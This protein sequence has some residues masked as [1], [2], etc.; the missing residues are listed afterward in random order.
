MRRWVSLMAMRRISW[1]D[2]RIKNDASVEV[3]AFFWAMALC[4]PDDG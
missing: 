3:A 1:S 4:W 2:Q